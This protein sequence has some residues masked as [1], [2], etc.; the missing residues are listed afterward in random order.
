MGLFGFVVTAKTGR[1]DEKLSG[2]G[3]AHICQLQADVG[4][5][6]FWNCQSLKGLVLRGRAPNLPVRTSPCTHP[7]KYSAFPM[8]M[9]FDASERSDCETSAAYSSNNPRSFR[10]KSS[11]VRP[12]SIVVFLSWASSVFILWD[13]GFHRRGSPSIILT[14][15]H[16][17]SSHFGTPRKFHRPKPPKSLTSPLQLFWTQLHPAAPSVGAVCFL[18]Q[19]GAAGHDALSDFLRFAMARWPD[20]PMARFFRSFSSRAEPTAPAVSA[21]FHP[22]FTRTLR[23]GVSRSFSMF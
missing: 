8:Y 17:G 23:R 21:R 20:H 2:V 5:G 11:S 10:L 19:P 13:L 16:G 3:R 4:H 7:T 1:H 18:V 14:M 15:S 6:P 9:D 22:T 12:S